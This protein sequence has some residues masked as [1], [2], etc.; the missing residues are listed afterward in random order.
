VNSPSLTILYRKERATENFSAI[1]T[2]NDKKI[3]REEWIQRFGSAEGFD[4]YDLN[5]DGFISPEESR[6]DKLA[7]NPLA[8]IP[9]PVSFTSSSKTNPLALIPWLYT[10]HLQAHQKLIPWL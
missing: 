4:D 5:G 3:S 8:L 7:L 10:C 9:W 2:N 1:D 6:A